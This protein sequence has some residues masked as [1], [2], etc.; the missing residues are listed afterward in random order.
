[1]KPSLLRALPT[2]LAA[3]GA[4][5]AAVAFAGLTFAAPASRAQTGQPSPLLNGTWRLATPRPQAQQ[6]IQQAIGPAVARLNP[7]MQRMARARLAESTWVPDQV[8][9]AASATQISIAVAGQE[10]RTF[11]STPGQPQNVYSRSG[12]RAS[13]TQLFRPDGA[14]EQQLRAMDG[15]QYNFYTPQAGGGAL[16]LDVLIQSQRLTGD[17]RFRVQFTR[18]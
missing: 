9:I 14:I 2:S 12:V 5:A 13:L 1:M 3:C 16:S 15:T 17:I 8:T 11:T 4:I 7:D 18:Q 6:S 10:N